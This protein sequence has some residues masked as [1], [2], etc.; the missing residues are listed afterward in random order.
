MNKG[1]CPPMS[2]KDY[3]N[4]MTDHGVKNVEMIVKYYPELNVFL[5][6]KSNG[7]F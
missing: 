3:F 7:I 5:K 4:L 6:E 2:D 1:M